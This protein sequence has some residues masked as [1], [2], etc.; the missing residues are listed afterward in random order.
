L[1]LK[2]RELCS[3]Q[4]PQRTR[5]KRDLVPFMCRGCAFAMIWCQTGEMF[6]SFAQTVGAKGPQFVQD[7]T[8]P[9]I[10]WAK[11]HLKKRCHEVSRFLTQ[12]GQKYSFGHC[13]RW[14]RS[15][16]QRRSWSS[17][18]RKSLHLAGAHCCQTITGASDRTCRR[19]ESCMRNWRYR[20]LPWIASR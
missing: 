12:S 20:N 4:M 10:G 14:R 6:F 13:R 2:I 1:P 15:A 9:Q 18:Q 16:H 3:L 11:G 17:S 5:V 19:S 8:P 7:A